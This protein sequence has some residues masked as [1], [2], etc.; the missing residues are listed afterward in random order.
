MLVLD[1]DHL[2]ILERP[3]SHL[4]RLVRQ[5]L[6]AARDQRIVTT[7]VNFEEQTRGRLAYLAQ[8]KS[9][10]EL[11]DAYA[12]L[13]FHLGVYRAVSVLSFDDLAAEKYEVFKHAKLR[14]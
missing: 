6:D 3:D 14:I 10:A 13:E 7:I 1:T 8:A 11:M 2:S 12:R 4:G 5:R 9:K